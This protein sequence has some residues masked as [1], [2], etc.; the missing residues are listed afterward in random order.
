MRVSI[1]ET[2]PA[3][4]AIVFNRTNA[5]AAVL[6][7]SRV[8]LGILIV[9]SPFRARIV[10]DQRTVGTIYGDYTDLL[11][12]WSD[13]SLLAVL[14]LWAGSLVLKPRTI[15]LGPNV[16][17]WAAGP[18]L[19][20]VWLSV[21]FSTDA[22]VSAFDALR[23]TAV[24]F[25]ALYVANEVE[26]VKQVVPALLVMVAVQATVAVSQVID[27]GS[28]G[29]GTLGEYHLNPQEPGSSIVWTENSAKLLRA[30]GFTDHP[31]ILGGLLAA[32]LTLLLSASV[33]SGPIRRSLITAV[34]AVGCVALLVTF[35]RAAQLALVAGAGTMLGLFAYRREWRRVALTLA[36]LG[37]AAVVA[38]GFVKPYWPYLSARLN[39]TE[40][41]AGST[42]RRSLSERAELVKV[43]NT[44]FT[45][46]PVAGVGFGA[47]PQA[48][49]R[50]FPDF[51]FNYQP[52]HFA[53]IDA[54]AETGVLGAMFYF[55]LLAAPWS[56]LWW[57]RK[58]LTPSL[59]GVSAAL[60][61][62]QV[63]GF[64]DYYTWSLAPGQV[65]AWL[66]LGLWT[67]AY[68]RMTGAAGRA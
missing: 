32:A 68:G 57:H 5:A 2:I 38:A 15:W 52:A 47:L 27:Q 25:L 37:V 35:S 60:L 17:R 36:C 53:L 65:W 31:N 39:P 41:Q 66:A 18:L 42:E 61:A 44:I 28:F 58:R 45:Q 12:F 55:L 34:F 43:S 13:V 54:A 11:V 8:A 21:P 24:A 14:A 6:A 63:I 1:A 23:L 9:L 40:Q 22:A 30:Y 10:L 49:A 62:V 64:F 16:V 59:I 26:D 20:A 4:P 33:R 3:R 50:E 48:M 67:S 56:L 7:L 19:A 46:H 29:L 51:G